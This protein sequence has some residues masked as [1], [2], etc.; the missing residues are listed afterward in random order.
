M[1]KEKTP[2]I[3]HFSDKVLKWFI[4]GELFEEVS[5]DLYEYY[6]ELE[7]LPAWK[8]KLFFWFHAL[9]FLRPFAIKQL[10]GT[11]KLN[12]YGMLKNY[13]ITAIRFIKREK[14][15]ALM[16]VSGLAL[17]IACALVIY[18][19]LDHEFSFDKHHTNY[20][21]IYRVNNEDIRSDGKI[22][23]KGQ[24]HPL[25]HALRN[26][27]PNLQAS[28]TYY[29]GDGLIGVEN[30]KG[31]IKRFQEQ[32]GIAFVEPEF[33][34]LFTL[35]FLE[36][37]EKSA[38]SEKGKVIITESKASKYFGL[39]GD[40]LHEAIGRSIL[41]ENEK[42]VYVS[43]VV[44]DMPKTTDFPFEV[45]F[46][47]M[48]QDAANPWFYDGQSWQEYN[49]ATNCFIMLKDGL[50]AAE[51]EKQL[52]P[53][54]D[55]YLPE[56]MAETRTYRLQPLSNLHY[57]DKIRAT[58][59]GV[60]ATNEE[61]IFLGLVGFFLIITACINFINLSTAQAV[62]RSKEVGVRKTMGS[63]K[64]QLVIQFLC[65][66]FVITLLATTVGFF[67]ASLLGG[68]VEVIF[69]NQMNIDLFSDS[70]I[71][72]FLLVMILGV[73][74]LAGLYPSFILARM[75]PVL[76]I[77][78]SLNLKQT[79]GF[80]SL[81][82]ALVVFQFAISQILII[83]ILILNAQMNFFKT[84]DL[85]FNDESVVVVKLPENDSTN[86]A[87]L[88]NEL[89]SHSSIKQVSFSSSAPMDDWR[90]TNPIFHPNTEGEDHN[91]NLKTVDENYFDLYEMDMIAGE[92]F[93]NNDPRS[94]VV[95]NRRVT[96]IIGFENP[97]E[98][99]GE[100]I[101]YGRGSLEFVIVGVV[102]DFHAISLHSDI[103]NVFM[104]NVRW[105]IFQAGIKLH[106]DQASFASIKTALNHIEESWETSFPNH[107]FDFEFYDDKVA[108]MYSLEESVSQVFKIFVTIAILIGALGLYGLVSF[109]A[110][111]KTKEI[112][113]RKVMGASEMSIWNIFSKELIT[114]LLIAFIIS[115]PIS[116][117][118]MRAFLD[119]YTYRIALGPGFFILAVVVSVVIAVVTVG[120]KSLKVAKA[121]PIL[122]LRD[123]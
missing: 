57:S 53:V 25:A 98:A 72:Y 27:F 88:R 117:F 9:N 29:E 51:L 34:E 5:G 16:N 121:N 3:L 118:L 4:K 43:A 84:K 113:I 71:I 116:Y 13:F 11:Q 106:S 21:R 83:G 112:G 108:S 12:Y 17:G 30:E 76:A 114:L 56:Y 22:H 111:Q 103:D 35:N 50:T 123:E 120:Y 8:R 38:L 61:L 92:P 115:G 64:S 107:V 24:V 74:L 54:V 96:E 60:T 26:D 58:Y 40:K 31:N 94:H 65:E 46:H 102:E 48:D 6:Y 85:G 33:L 99:L 10:E 52:E 2:Y 68:Q 18:K 62:K 15:F 91:G 89:L 73:T 109:M 1:Q 41:L 49:S 81:R 82:R 100:K 79:S 63:G 55:K 23:W 78:N 20:D 86:L 14:V 39:S 101:K 93:T 36:G 66:T 45:L 32:K 7:N 37:D 122:S 77:K 42:T 28:M 70:N 69:E 80:L 104:A 119:T 105:N 75:N 19:I 90:S 67:I 95:V 87:L 110:N 97:E 47:Y 44:E 59:A